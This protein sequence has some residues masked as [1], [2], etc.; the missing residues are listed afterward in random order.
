MEGEL[1]QEIPV[2]EKIKLIEKE[3]E[4]VT[5]KLETM[6]KALQE[7]DDLKKEIKG[8]K[9]FLGREYPEF[10]KKFPEVMQKVFRKS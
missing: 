6:N 10:K 8:L 5:D 9:L 2:K 1:K 3:I 7:M 4:T